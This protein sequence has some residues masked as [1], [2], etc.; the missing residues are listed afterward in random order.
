MKTIVL[1]RHAEAV[2]KGEQ[3]ITRDEDRPLTDKGREDAAK[4]AAAFV[5][6]GVTPDAVVTSPLVRA[7]Q[8]AEPILKLLP[9]G[10]KD[11]LFCGRLA[12]DE[13]RP[14]KLTRDLLGVTGGMIVVV[15]HNPSLSEYAGWLLG[16]GETAIELDKGAAALIEFDG[17][18]EK[19]AGRLRWLV[20]PGWL[21]GV[22]APV[23]G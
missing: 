21:V 13:Y 1:L 2:P 20:T 19:G 5:A 22:V 12:P 18:I 14:K 10:A 23:G 15:G 8:T 17:E 9:E 7:V 16:A 11:P 3:G 4:L 6:H